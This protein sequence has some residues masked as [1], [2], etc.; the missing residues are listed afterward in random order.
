MGLGDRGCPT[1]GGRGSGMEGRGR[2]G[3]GG[4]WWGTGGRDWSTGVGLG[5]RGW[6][7]EVGDSWDQ[8]EETE[9]PGL[10]VLERVGLEVRR[11]QPWVGK[12][13]GRR[14]WGLEGGARGVRSRVNW[15]GSEE[16]RC[17]NFAGRAGPEGAARGPRRRHRSRSS[18]RQGVRPGVCVCISRHPPPTPP[19]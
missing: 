9:Q 6:R 14:G 11:A 8:E 4:E 1:G 16:Y 18:P 2:M 10:G 7:G 19:R 13:G 3:T 15:V 17:G 12:G 5:V